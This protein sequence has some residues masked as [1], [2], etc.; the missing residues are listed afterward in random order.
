MLE[1]MRNAT[2]MVSGSARTYA[3]VDRGILRASIIPEVRTEGKTV[4]GVVGSNKIHA[5]FPET[6]TRPH[7]PPLAALETWAA[8]H[9]TTAFVVAR[10][11]AQRGTRAV[12][13]LQRAFD[14]H[15]NSIM[16]LIGRGV[17]SIIHNKRG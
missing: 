15:R 16:E 6:G 4:I 9:G 3:P 17:D 14:E 2:L 10:A 7:W 12:H 5:P 8:R 11:I 13:Y 1:T